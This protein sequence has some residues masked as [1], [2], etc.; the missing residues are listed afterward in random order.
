[1]L[2][3]HNGPE[4]DAHIFESEVGF[5]FPLYQGSRLLLPGGIRILSQE[6]D[7]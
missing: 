4:R 6:T 2:E 5:R 1:M 7:S 3:R